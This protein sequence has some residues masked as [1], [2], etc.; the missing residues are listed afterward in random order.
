MFS[1]TKLVVYTLNMETNLC[2]TVKVAKQPVT[3]H[4]LAKVQQLMWEFYDTG[5]L[6]LAR[7]EKL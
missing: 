1:V 2:S 7:T 3:V 5:K 6:P 4:R